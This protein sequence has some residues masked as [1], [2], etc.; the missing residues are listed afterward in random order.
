MNICR[1]ALCAA[2]ALL[3]CTH[4]HAET[5]EIVAIVDASRPAKGIYG[6]APEQMAS[7][8]DAQLR[9]TPDRRFLLAARDIKERLTGRAEQVHLDF[10][11][12][13]WMVR[14]GDT[15]AFSLPELP[16]F[17]DGLDALTA[18][19]TKLRKSNKT[20]FASLA[21]EAT[22]LNR[23]QADRFGVADE[24]RAQA[25]ALI[26]LARSANPNAAAADAATMADICGYSTEAQ[27]RGVAPQ[28]PQ[29]AGPRKLSPDI[30]ALHARAI[31]LS[32]L[33][34]EYFDAVE[35]RG[36]RPESADLAKACAI[37]PDAAASDADRWIRDSVAVH[38]NRG[39]GVIIDKSIA[40]VPHIGGE[41][42]AELLLAALRTFGGTTAAVR[43]AAFAIFAQCDTRPSQLYFL[44][45]IASE[46]LDDPSRRDLY[47]T[48]ALARGRKNLEPGVAGWIP[49]A[50][51]DEAGLRAIAFSDA[52]P[53]GERATALQNL[54]KLDGVDQ[55]Q[56]AAVFETLIAKSSDAF[57]SFVPW[58]NEHHQWALKERLARRALPANENAIG[59][60]YVAASLADA[61][62]R[63]GR[64]A[65]ALRTVK[66]FTDVW[67]FNIISATMQARAA[68][69]D[70]Q[71]ADELAQSLMERYPGTPAN[72]DCARVLWTQKRYAEAAAL[73]DPKRYQLLPL[74]VASELAIAFDG[75]FD[76]AQTADAVA[77]FAPIIPMISGDTATQMLRD[78]EFYHRDAL[79]FRLGE[80]L[81]DDPAHRSMPERVVSWRAA[82]A[83][84]GP[85]AA[86]EWLRTRV[87]DADRVSLVLQA[88]QDADELVAEYALPAVSPRKTAEMQ[89]II[90]ASLVRL[91]VAPTDPRFAGLV[92]AFSAQPPTNDFYNQST[93]Y[94]L[95]IGDSRAAFA[96]GKDVEARASVAYFRGIRAAYEGRYDEAMSW[97]LAAE[98]IPNELGWP[99]SWTLGQLNRWNSAHLAW[100]EIKRRRVP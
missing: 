21:H 64:N 17:A 8:V 63:Q 60:A 58:A 59:Q 80:R 33:Y 49:S 2:A 4:P 55:Q 25:L 88:H 42:R 76:D 57:Y 53:A 71:G 13:R 73:L 98:A 31:Q 82:R 18:F 22:Q 95:G 48:T 6:V 37:S 47:L 100:S 86:S 3:A 38:F 54:A 81:L 11:N 26:A 45:R 69:G 61:L 30:Y 32:S 24:E 16:T 96:A 27:A 51:G 44:G 94:L 85:A 56:V 34:D 70:R 5:A 43:R 65:D 68:N 67:S 75:T 78:L 1:L 19:A 40:A 10:A 93:R 84:T 50:T 12:G 92:D 66:P 87:G 7:V 15:D 52:E 39:E 46:I 89:L 28:P 97:L 23:Q 29:P 74:Q 90:A 83:V 36:S 99:L 41:R 77:A 79:A 72:V 35:Q 9:V 14:V 62:M 20:D 91:H